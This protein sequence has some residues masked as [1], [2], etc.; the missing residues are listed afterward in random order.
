[1]YIIIVIGVRGHIL[2][3]DVVAE[4]L[5]VRLRITLFYHVMVHVWN[6]R[7]A[8]HDTCRL[9]LI[10]V[11]EDLIVFLETV[12]VDSFQ[13]VRSRLRMLLVEFG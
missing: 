13:D 8:R 4:V 1:M 12:P 6:S 9:D 11:R 10:E 7:T 3:W 5:R 2:Y